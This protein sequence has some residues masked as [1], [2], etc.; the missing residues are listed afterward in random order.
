M[1]SN[2]NPD[3]QSQIIQINKKQK[4]TKKNKKTGHVEDQEE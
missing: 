3:L 1:K 2:A 4:K